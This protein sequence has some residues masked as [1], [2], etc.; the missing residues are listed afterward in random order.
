MRFSGHSLA[1]AV[2][3]AL[4]S[5]MTWAAEGDSALDRCVQ[6]QI[7]K[8]FAQ[9]RP[10]CVEA[11][12]QSS[13]G[14]V[15][16]GDLLD[17][18]GDVEAAIE[19]YTKVVEGADPAKYTETQILALR[20]RAIVRTNAGIEPQAA[21]EDAK[22]VLEYMPDDLDV[23]GIID[24]LEP[25]D[26]VAAK[27]LDR[28]LEFHPKQAGLHVSRGLRYYRMKNYKEALAS[29]ATALKLRPKD[30]AA[31]TLRGYVY[32]AMGEHAKALREHTAAVRAA[33]DEP[34]PKVNQAI[35]LYELKRYS[36]VVQAATAAL[37]LAQDIDAVALRATAYL[38][39]GE[40]APALADIAVLEQLQPELDVRGMKAR[41]EKLALGR[42]VL[43]P[44]GLVQMEADRQRILADVQRHLQGMCGTFR[45]PQFNPGIDID[46]LNERMDK[47]RQCFRRWLS[48]GSE[49]VYASLSDSLEAG[50]RLYEAHSA[51]ITLKDF[52]CSQRPKRSNC[53]KDDLYA[54]AE[55]ATEGIYEPFEYVANA[56]VRRFNQDLD[57]FNRAV[58]R[59]NT[60]VEVTNFLDE[61][62]R[63]LNE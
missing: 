3:A 26:E 60:T 6:L 44:E 2:A 23:L 20:H 52:R 41:A 16:Y 45:M 1:A 9:A 8:Q 48:L 34:R 14:V 56:E 36:E 22:V 35:V 59:H 40:G 7:E 38:Q 62:G 13:E 17:S 10:F 15:R 49:E 5:S 61:L 32:T 46:A 53:V 50:E 28:A 25:S 27:Y 33:P 4:V 47:Y 21:L 42:Q 39:L 18:E 51:F 29:A 43:T 63:A 24:D 54:R 31:L 30:P 11:A 19:Q 57:A 37:Q 58:Q 12:G 55:A